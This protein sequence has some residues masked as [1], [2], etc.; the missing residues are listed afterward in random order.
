ME[1]ITQPR[2]ANVESKM[3][4]ALDGMFI[5]QQIYLYC[6]K[7]LFIDIRLFVNLV[8]SR[9]FGK[10]SF[11]VFVSIFSGNVVGYH[12]TLPCQS[13][14]RSCNNGHFWMFHSSAVIPVERLDQTGL[15]PSICHSS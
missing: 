11:V 13:C 3:S 12:V 10:L 14:I 1:Q 8:I 9:D 7:S 4:P 5:S 6:F 15:L 2:T